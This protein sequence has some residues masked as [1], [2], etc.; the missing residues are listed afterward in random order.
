MIS[1]IF[2]ITNVILAM[3]D[4]LMDDSLRSRKTLIIE[5]RYDE[6]SLNLLKMKDFGCE[7]VK[8]NFLNCQK[9][10]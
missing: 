10:K 1:S 2:A 5:D 6:F 9:S 3:F 7:F 8:K 4:T